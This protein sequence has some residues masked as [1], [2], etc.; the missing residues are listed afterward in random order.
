MVFSD[1]FR[2]KCRRHCPRSTY[3]D[4]S[5]GVC[6]SCPAPCEDCRSNT[7]CITCQ[8]GYFLN[9]TRITVTSLHLPHFYH[10]NILWLLFLSC[11][12]LKFF[13][14]LSNK[15]DCEHLPLLKTNNCPQS[16]YLV[17]KSDMCQQVCRK[18][19]ANVCF[20]QI[21]NLYCA[22]LHRHMRKHLKIVPKK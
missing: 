6:L 1:S 22:V 4:R 13:G 2:Q 3:E 15:W 7:L 5:S 11:F 9:G 14:I 12:V 10:V 16:L 20:T 18:S 17:C 8:P 19:Y 21:W